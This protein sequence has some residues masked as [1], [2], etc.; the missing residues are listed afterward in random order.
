MDEL[1]V[2]K[3]KAEKEELA[4]YNSKIQELCLDKNNPTR[5]KEEYSVLESFDLIARKIR[6]LVRAKNP[7]AGSFLF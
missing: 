7:D 1:G 2:D 6:V 3:M 4:A 5:E